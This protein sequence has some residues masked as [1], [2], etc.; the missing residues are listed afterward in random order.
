MR[1]LDEEDIAKRPVMFQCAYCRC[2]FIADKTEYVTHYSQRED[3]T[4]HDCRCPKCSKWCPSCG[5]RRG[6]II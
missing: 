3:M 6:A 4:W 5:P 2:L 1:I